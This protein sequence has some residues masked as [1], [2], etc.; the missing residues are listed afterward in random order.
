MNMKCL[1]QVHVSQVASLLT[2]TFIQRHA[3]RNGKS[4]LCKYSLFRSRRMHWPSRKFGTPSTARYKLCA[5]IRMHVC[6][7]DRVNLHFSI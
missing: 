2:F 1:F 7:F 4:S 3:E 5:Y 6:N